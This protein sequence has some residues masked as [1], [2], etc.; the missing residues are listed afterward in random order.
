M[1]TA[2]MFELLSYCRSPPKARITITIFNFK[3]GPFRSLSWQR[4]EFLPNM[5]QIVQ[6]QVVFFFLIL[7]RPHN[8]YAQVSYVV[9]SF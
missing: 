1:F 8:L 3:L 6:N 9:F 2:L 5:E 7:S 4:Q